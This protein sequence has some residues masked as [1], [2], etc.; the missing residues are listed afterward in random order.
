MQS[1]F[2]GIKN[3][4]CNASW[5]RAMLWQSVIKERAKDMYMYVIALWSKFQPW[6]GL[7]LQLLIFL[8]QLQFVFLCIDI[9]VSLSNSGDMTF[10]IAS[11]QHVPLVILQRKNVTEKIYCFS[12]LK[13][14]QVRAPVPI[15][16]HVLN[17]TPEP[18]WMNTCNHN[19]RQASYGTQIMNQ[20]I[21]RFSLKV[22]T[23]PINS[24]S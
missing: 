20:K 2:G 12:G 10:W 14:T 3:E 8:P 17:L 11:R 6:T 9:S 13:Q 21:W 24:F 7:D 19:E 15:F 4:W 16:M 22:E 1:G 5:V 23:F 18:N